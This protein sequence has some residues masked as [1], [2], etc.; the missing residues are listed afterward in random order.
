MTPNLNT[1][2]EHIG[3]RAGSAQLAPKS[4]YSPRAHLPQSLRPNHDTQRITAISPKAFMLSGRRHRA[5]SLF[6][7]SWNRQMKLAILLPCVVTLCLFIGCG[8]ELSEELRVT[9]A[10]V[11]DLKATVVRLQSELE[12]MN[13]TVAELRSGLSSTYAETKQI[14][15]IVDIYGMNKD[16]LSLRVKAMSLID[17]DE[18]TRLEMVADAERQAVLFLDGRPILAR[19][20]NKAFLIADSLVIEDAEHPGTLFAVAITEEGAGLLMGQLQRPSVR[21]NSGEANNP[22]LLLRGPEG[23]NVLIDTSNEHGAVIELGAKGKERIVLKMGRSGDPSV[24]IRGADENAIFLGIV[25]E[26][27]AL[28]FNAAR[29]DSI[30]ELLGKDQ[31]ATTRIISGAAGAGI[32]LKDSKGERII[33]PGSP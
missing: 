3:V 22:N 13:T 23:Q 26:L 7:P 27:A 12:S 33:A 30:V 10:Q 15:S 16:T 18:N 6:H 32:G 1:E 4:E 14:K 2:G 20:K 19:R 29:G 17:K 8:K 28:G 31:R 9:T 21:V 11:D 25:G 5:F 24:L